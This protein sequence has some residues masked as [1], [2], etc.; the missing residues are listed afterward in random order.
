MKFLVVE[1]GDTRM[2]LQ[3]NNEN[4]GQYS[5]NKTQL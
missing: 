3:E 2:A 5:K 4:V 1:K